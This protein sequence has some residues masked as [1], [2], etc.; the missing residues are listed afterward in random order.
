MNSLY[1][2]GRMEESRDLLV[3]QKARMETL[4]DC[5]ISGPYYFW[6]GH[7]YSHLGDNEGADSSAKRAIEEGQRC[8]DLGT[9]GRGH[10]V[11]CREGFFTGRLVEGVEHGRKAVSLLGRAG[12]AGGSPSPTSLSA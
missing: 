5:R 11:I 8:E 12:S 2:L 9:M 10:Y 4:G 6:L 7:T 3:D 1:F